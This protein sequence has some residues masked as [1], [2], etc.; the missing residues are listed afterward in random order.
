MLKVLWFGLS[1]L[2][3][4]E[5]IF[6]LKEQGNAGGVVRLARVNEVFASRACRKSV[7]VGTKLT[8]SKMREVRA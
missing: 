1:S 2:D 4:Q 6:L 8:H 3:V 7:M 5:M